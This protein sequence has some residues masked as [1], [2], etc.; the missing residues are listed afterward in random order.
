MR[1]LVVAFGFSMVHVVENNNTF[2][3]EDWFGHNL[4]ETKL[5]R[6]KIGLVDEEDHLVFRGFEPCWN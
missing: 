4:V 5:S 1:H 6:D 2:L 3:I